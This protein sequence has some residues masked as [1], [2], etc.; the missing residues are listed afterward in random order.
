MPAR[1][2][3]ITT[4]TKQAQS[5]VIT[6]K[7]SQLLQ[8]A[9][10]AGRRGKDTEGNV[11]IMKNQYDELK[12]VHQLLLS[13]VDSIKSQFRFTYKFVLK[14]LL[15]K[16]LLDCR[17]LL[18]RTFSSYVHQL[19][20]QKRLK[21]EE[22]GNVDSIHIEQIK[23][24]LEDDKDLHFRILL[25]YPMSIVKDYIKLY[26]K[27]SKEYRNFRYLEDKLMQGQIDF[28]RVSTS[29]AYFAQ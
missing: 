23:S 21:Q 7:T 11:I 18:E 4:V 12:L 13:K 5:K 17:L 1:T 2:T 27:L 3:I 28:H 22:E 19:R 6:L 15:H 16:T 24:P 26:A 20:K 14:L 10:R 25:Q 9:G 29:V 8:M